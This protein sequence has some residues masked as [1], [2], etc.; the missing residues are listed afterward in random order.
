[1]A[2]PQELQ[3]GQLNPQ[4]QPV[5]TFIQSTRRNVAGAARPE[6]LPNTPQLLTSQTG[7]TTFVQGE[8]S[9]A[10]LAADLKAFSPQLMATAET[11]GLKYVDWQ[12]DVGEQM[13][14][15]QVQ[16]GLAQIDEQT[17]V[18]ENQR[19]ADNRKVSAADPEAGWL[20][21]TLNP[22]QQIGFNRGKVKMAGQQIALGLPAFIAEKGKEI[23]PT[24][25]RPFID[26]RAP[27]MGYAG[28]QKLQAQYQL[29][30][31]SQ[32]GINSG[33]PGYTK[34]FAPNLIRAQSQVSEALIDQRTQFF[35]SQIG[36][37]AISTTMSLMEGLADDNNPITTQEGIVIPRYWSDGTVNNQWYRAKAWQLTTQVKDLLATAPLGAA[38]KITEQLYEEVSKSFPEGSVQRK[39]LRLMEVSQGVTYGNRY[40]YK[41]REANLQFTA[42]EAKRIRDQKTI[43]ENTFL[44]VLGQQLQI[45]EVPYGEAVDNTIAIINADRKANGLPPLTPKEIAG[46]KALGANSIQE[47]APQRAAPAQPPANDPEAASINLARVNNTPLME[48]DVQKERQILEQ[49]RAGGMTK[50]QRASYNAAT[51]RLDEAEKAQQE[52]K[53]WYSQ[54]GTQATRRITDYVKKDLGLLF[55]DVAP[56]EDKLKNEVISRMDARLSAL[57]N[58]GPVRLEDINREFIDVWKTIDTDVKNGVI[59]IDGTG[60]TPSNNPGGPAPA[61]PPEAGMVPGVNLDQLNNFPRRNN[62]LRNWRAEK[63]PILSAQALIQ[64]I[65]DAANGRKEDPNFTKAWKTA[66]APNAWSFIQ[67]QM[68]F[69]NNLGGGKGWTDEDL[70]KA[71][72]DLLSYVIRD[73]NRYG[74]MTLARVSPGLAGLNNWAESL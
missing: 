72:Q 67:R 34:Y 28:L 32:Y 47:I 40:G 52:S 8:N 48:I 33:S 50:E 74:T 64:V 24:T 16:R 73:G 35:E 45:P 68:Q 53:S 56:A 57:R 11:A 66:K 55:D 4:S 62:R 18:A 58:K 7:G 54:Y 27:D 5:S 6:L 39:V 49:I 59:Q 17:E 23:D 38:S 22:Y 21:R 9:F 46:L 26:F 10:R 13:A 30:L 1:M 63:S 44:P 69:Y 14:M 12:M 71:K 29:Q 43:D 19:A 3:P 31:E 61:A 2:R 42:D 37:Q 20:M 60:V 70:E 41:D 36:P 25:G 51:G 15:E 65:Q